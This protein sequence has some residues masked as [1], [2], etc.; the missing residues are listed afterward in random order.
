MSID[1][2]DPLN[3]VT[4]DWASADNTATVAGS[5]YVGTSGTLTFP[6][7][8]ATLTQTVA[9]TVNGDTTVEP[10]ETFFVNLSNASA[11]ATLADNQ[12][13]GT[14]TNDDSATVTVDDVSAVEGTG[15]TFTVTLD[16]AVAVPFT[17]DVTLADVTATGGAAPL[18]SPEDYDNV[19]AT[20]NFAGTAGETQQFTVATLDDALFEGAETF[21]ASLN[22]SD[23][24]ITD[25]DIV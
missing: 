4:V 24:L 20:L 11:N 10:N 1:Q 12:G 22:A 14:I 16:N 9:I 23:P 7:G 5:D 18:A 25:T 21:T 6:A 19:V 2:A 13:L 15:L 8:T 3:P 17:V